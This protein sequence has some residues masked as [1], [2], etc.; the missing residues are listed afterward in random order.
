MTF[1]KTLIKNL[2]ENGEEKFGAKYF[3]S[4]LH[5]HTPASSDARG[6]NK[7]DFNPY[8]D[9]KYP[10]D[11]TAPDYKSEVEKIH[12]KIEKESRELA[13]QIVERFVE[14]DLSLVAVTDHNG[15]GTIWADDELEKGAMDLAAPT[16]Y[17]LIDWEAKKLNNKMNRTVLTIL[18]GVE[19]STTGIHILA[20]FPNEPPRRKAHYIICDLLNEA[21]FKIDSWGVVREVGTLSAVDTI[22]LIVKK[23]G[24]PIPAHIDGENQGLLK[25]YNI[26]SG[27]MKNVLKLHDLNAVEIVKPSKFS[28]KDKKLKKTLK[29][30]IDGVRRKEGLSSLAYFQGSDA[31]CL[32]DISKR[33]T[34]VKMTEPSFSGLRTAVRMPNSRVRISSLYE[35][36]PEGMF[37][38]SMSFKN[39]FFGKKEVRFNRHLNC[40]TGKRDSGKTVL[41]DLMRKASG[42]PTDGKKDSVSMFIEKITDSKSSY[43]AFSIAVNKDITRLFQVDPE[44]QNAV[45]IDMSKAKKLGILPKFYN[46]TKINDIISSNNNLNIFLKK[47]FGNPTRTNME[48][49]NKMFSIPEFLGAENNQL[50]KLKVD[51]NSYKLSVN[52]RW[53]EGKEKFRDFS[54]ASL[55]LRRTAMMCMI[56]IL[57]DLGPAIINA[58]EMYF[59]SEDIV[60]YLVPV[61]KRYKDSQQIIIFSNSPVFAVNTDPDNYIVLQTRGPKFAGFQY[62]FAIDDKEYRPLLLNILEG[63]LHAFNNRAEKY[64]DI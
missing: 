18:P 57:S 63:S 33:H 31:H 15:I 43:Y 11:K 14:E 24:I 58:P 16:W 47:Y 39:S 30:W 5:F 23:G 52:L 64:Q 17:E 26:T 55:S 19:I 28:K 38:H 7:Y 2:R 29:L 1:Q 8:K 60:D 13:K 10:S 56:I 44:N 40:V 46:S 36:N 27:A 53:N 6:S 48:K 3:K 51:Q 50:L 34:Y 42:V 25:L 22:K 20:V 32:P 12:K 54:R 62:G 41:F 45:E 9:V 61:I 4:D 37:I 35:P 59:D 21:G 49:F